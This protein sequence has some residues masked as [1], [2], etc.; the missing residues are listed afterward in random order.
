M[1]DE[2]VEARHNLP[3]RRRCSWTCWCWPR[4]RPPPCGP[5]ETSRRRPRTDVATDHPIEEAAS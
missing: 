5:I 1:G 3:R 2:V 4:W